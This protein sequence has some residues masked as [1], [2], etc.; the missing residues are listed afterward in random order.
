MKTN[1]WY[2]KNKKVDANYVPVPVL[3][4][5]LMDPRRYDELKAAAAAQAAK[6]DAE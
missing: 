6:E 3:G 1:R 2:D 4:P 5:D